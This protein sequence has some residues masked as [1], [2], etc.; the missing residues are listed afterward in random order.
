MLNNKDWKDILTEIKP[1]IK[2]KGVDMACKDKKDAK[3]PVNPKPR[4]K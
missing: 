3:K 2:K 1:L 4:G